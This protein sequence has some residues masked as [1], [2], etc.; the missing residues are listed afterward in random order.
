[1]LIGAWWC[2]EEKILALE[3]FLVEGRKKLES[4]TDKAEEQASRLVQQDH[5]LKQALDLLQQKEEELLTSKRRV[6]SLTTALAET[7]DGITRVKPPAPGRSS[8]A[9][10]RAE[11]AVPR[12]KPQLQPRAAPATVGR[13]SDGVSAAVAPEREAVASVK[14]RFEEA[15]EPEPVASPKTEEAVRRRRQPAPPTLRPPLQ[16]KSADR[17]TAVACALCEP[18]RAPGGPDVP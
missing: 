7:P 1:M 17:C 5:G 6:R 8:A 16:R 9:R 3:K 4:A 13:G 12:S 11:E 18:F 2:A 10:P 14:Q 15:E